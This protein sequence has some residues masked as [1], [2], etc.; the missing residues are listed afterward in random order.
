MRTKAELDILKEGEIIY[1]LKNN[2]R[3][4]IVPMKNPG[5]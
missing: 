2:F 5:F 4:S 3:S 1:I